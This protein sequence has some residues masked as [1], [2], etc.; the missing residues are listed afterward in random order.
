MINF[1]E[2][3]FD[4]NQS[5]IIKAIFDE[6]L[7]NNW[8]NHDVSVKYFELSGSNV[9]YPSLLRHYESLNRP[10]LIQPPTSIKSH[11]KPVPT[12]NRFNLLNDQ[13][14][15]IEIVQVVT[16]TSKIL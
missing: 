8:S 13:P 9:S 2:K 12:S 1:E 6:R 16:N 14:D 4:L 10:A 7:A 5:L 3:V 15:I 11:P